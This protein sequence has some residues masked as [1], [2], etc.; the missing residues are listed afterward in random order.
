[1]DCLFSIHFKN[2]MKI[3]HKVGQYGEDMACHFLQQEGFTIITRNWHCPFG[4]LDIVAQSKKLLLFVEVKYRKKSS[5]GGV[6]YSITPAKLRKMRKSIECY[7]QQNPHRGDIRAD[8]ILIED[9]Q[10]LQ[11]IKNIME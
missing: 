7:L 9:N 5:F 10:P 4:E 3:N 1:M 2:F 6:I 8:A 11:H